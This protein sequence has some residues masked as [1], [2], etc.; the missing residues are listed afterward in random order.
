[1]STKPSWGLSVDEAKAV[2][3]KRYVNQRSNYRKLLLGDMPFPIVLSLKAPKSGQDIIANLE[4]FRQFVEDWR[5]VEGRRREGHAYDVLWQTQRYQRL[6]EQRVPVQ[7]VAYSPEGLFQFIGGEAMREWETDERL[8][9]HLV[10]SIDVAEPLMLRRALIQQLNVIEE[11]SADQLQQLIQLIPQLQPRMGEG[12][13]LR[14]LPVVGVDTKFIEQFSTLIEAVVDVKYAGTVKEMGLLPWLGCLVRPMDWLL[15]RPLC[16]HS[17]ALL[18]GLRILRL[19]TDQLLTYP[20]PASNILIIENE[21]SCL[22]LDTVADT[23]AVSGGG[24]NLSWL[25][26]EWLKQKRVAYWGDIDSE[27]LT[28]LSNARSRVPH[29]RALMMSETEVNRYQQR[30]VAEP[31]SVFKMPEHLSDDE[32]QLFADLRADVYLGRRL[33][34]ERLDRDYVEAKVLSWASE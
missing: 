25:A 9:Q 32:V 5:D 33:E 6:S 1:M 7:L 26:A 10:S 30:M 29:L 28:M 12:L 22:A 23:I 13:Y 18:A 20:L 24:K 27:G 21:Q 19:S 3:R 16:E 8:L 14:A 17:R 4:H 31:A 11:M 34:Q 15:I 2:W